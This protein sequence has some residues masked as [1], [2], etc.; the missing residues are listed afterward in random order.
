MK[1]MAIKDYNKMQEV[2][3]RK[4]VAGWKPEKGGFPF[5]PMYFFYDEPVIDR[6]IQRSPLFSYLG[7]RLGAN[8]IPHGEDG[9]TVIHN[10]ISGDPNMHW[11]DLSAAYNQFKKDRFMYHG[12][13]VYV[14]T[15]HLS[16]RGS[17][18][19]ANMLLSAKKSVLPKISVGTSSIKKEQK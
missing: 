6:S 19:L 4:A 15:S 1:V 3:Y 5:R 8:V 13:P 7:I 11:V 14:D 17:R 18:A 12:W 2:K 9:N 10:L 16:G